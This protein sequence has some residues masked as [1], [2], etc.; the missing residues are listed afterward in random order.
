LQHPEHR[1]NH[2]N[3]LRLLLAAGVLLCHCFP[4]TQGHRIF[5]G[6]PWFEF[7]S[8][9]RLLGTTCV[10]GFFVISGYLVSLSFERAAHLGVYF[11]ARL[12]RIYPAAIVCAVL[13]GVLLGPLV[14]SGG[15]G[16]YLGTPELKRFLVQ[17]TTFASFA[18][19]DALPGTFAGN[20]MP[21]VMNGSLWTISWE[22][23]CYVLLVPFGFVLY[24]SEHRWLRIWGYSVI[25]VFAVAGAAQYALRPL[26]NFLAG[27]VTFWGFFCV[28]ILGRAVLPKLPLRP[29][30]T[31]AAL[32]VFLVI[33]SFEHYAPA[34]A[35]ASPFLFGYI[36]LTAASQLPHS[37]LRYNK[38]G[39][40]SYG[41]Y[42][43]AWPVQQT[44]I[45]VLPAIGAWALFGLALPVA[46]LLAIPSWYLV[47]RPALRLKTAFA[48][49]SLA[50]AKFQQ[51]VA[52]SA[53]PP[54]L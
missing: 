14:Y 48:L 31:V 19:K 12:L 23:F 25:A 26:P 44:L 17:T 35:I 40:F 49:P 2:F 36:L 47:E 50:R 53:A 42:L 4:L 45:F 24:R 34:M 51:V 5:T 43:Y 8:H 22:L 3:L 54:T 32:A 21:G 15:I 6:E 29:W 10:L 33:E 27:P 46:M 20:P 9:Q 39:D 38:F 52:R 16:Q 28:G 37:W 11:K 41:L 13:T 18:L 30:M 1:E 7:T